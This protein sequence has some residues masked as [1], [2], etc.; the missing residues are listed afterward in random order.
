MGP[1]QPITSRA[2]R[3]SMTGTISGDTRSSSRPT[4]SAIRTN[5]SQPKGHQSQSSVS[6]D[7]HPGGPS[8]LDS[9]DEEPENDVLS[10]SSSGQSGEPAR[11]LFSP[12][13]S[14]VSMASRDLKAPR[15][16]APHDRAAPITASSI[17]QNRKIEELET[18]LRSKDKE[19]V[20][21]KEKLKTSEKDRGERE[22]LA[23][24]IARLESKL[25]PQQQELTKLKKQ[26]KEAEERAE[27]SE[28]Q[29]AEND[30]ATEMAAL[31]REMAE[32]TAE[33][34]RQE[35]DDMRQKHEELVLEVEVLR[36]ENAELG[37]EMSPE[38]KTSQNWLRMVQ[39]NEKLRDALVQLRDITHDQETEFRAHIEE[40]E[41]DVEA[42]GVFKAQYEDTKTK[43]EQIESVSEELRQQL[44]SA[45]GAED[46]I[47]ELTEKNMTLN[48]QL[49]D[50]K[51]TVEELESLKEL[52]DELELNHT[53]TE[54]QMQEEI[55]YKDSIL[56]KVLR[57][58]AA[59]DEDIEELEY[60]VT[61]FRELVSNLQADL[62]DIRSSQQLT[63]AE[64]NEL[65]SKSRA[66]MDLNMRLQ[67]SASKTQIKA[68]DLEL[69]RLEA[70]EWKE[71]LS[72]VQLFLPE[73]YSRHTTSVSAFLCIQRVGF[74]STLLHTFLKER[75]NGQASP[76]HED[77]MFACCEILGKL[78]W[79][80]A[81]SDRFTNFFR[82]CSL[83]DFKGLANAV[84]DLE[85]VERNLDRIIDALKNNDLRER[86]VLDDLQRYAPSKHRLAI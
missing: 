65:T 54:K 24:I 43:L 76:G 74:K 49:D 42:L 47:E 20:E 66:M 21:H 7:S 52:N 56:S 32:E 25:Q 23:N 14:T 12:P 72:I 10:P 67:T 27:I 71:H 22:R 75:V 16:P 31:D 46:M 81:M 53:E 63:E 4:S 45:L 44:D 18:R 5:V 51:T 8:D 78:T 64:A 37:Q 70:Q 80:T 30:S 69:R 48:E 61:R 86:Q 34:A 62:E 3:P 73:S 85:P 55:D 29:Q 6:G 82:S 11:A 83:E 28:K 58:S 50:L 33:S 35:L 13:L 39:T 60:T 9:L 77:E 17:T 40:L 36:E 84:L 19:L 79:V 57:K 2:P 59:Q 38:E 41:Q 26:V 68:I 1:S 15:L